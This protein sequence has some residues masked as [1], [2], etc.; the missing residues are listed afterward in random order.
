[1]IKCNLSRFMGERRLKIA[2]VVRDTGLNRGTI[3]RM[4]HETAQRIDLGV[5]DTLCAYFCCDISE[6]YERVDS[7]IDLN[8]AYKTKE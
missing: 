3:T 8:N 1:M 6:L 2:D 7:G 5:V 4:Y